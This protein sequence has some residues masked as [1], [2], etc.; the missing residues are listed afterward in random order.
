MITRLLVGRLTPAIR[1][2][3]FSMLHRGSDP[4]GGAPP[5][6]S[7]SSFD[8]R[9]I[10]ERQNGR[11]VRH[12]ACLPTAPQLSNERRAY[13]ESETPSTVKRAYAGI[14]PN[15]GPPASQRPLCYTKING[16]SK[17]ARRRSVLGAREVRRKAGEL[18]AHHLVDQQ[19]YLGRRHTHVPADDVVPGDL[20]A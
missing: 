15:N 11:L 12:L 2:T 20:R 5:I 1:A 17:S 9:G 13:G 6:S 18:L 10:A 14:G 19:R 8:A 7:L 4:T 3:N 16:P